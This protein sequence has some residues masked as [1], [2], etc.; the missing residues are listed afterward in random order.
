M[1]RRKTD[2]NGKHVEERRE[3]VETVDYVGDSTLIKDP[4]DSRFGR[5]SQNVVIQLGIGFCE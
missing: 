2:V 5:V 3:D 1:Q 4:Q